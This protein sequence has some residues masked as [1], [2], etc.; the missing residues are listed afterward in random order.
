MN[1]RGVIQPLTG[2]IAIWL[3]KC[4]GTMATA[5][6]YTGWLLSALADKPAPITAAAIKVLRNVRMLLLQ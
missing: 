2:T 3:P 5:G 4:T 6:Q 1:P